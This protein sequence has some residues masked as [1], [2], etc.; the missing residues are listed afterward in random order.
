MDYNSIILHHPITEKAGKHNLSLCPVV[1]EMSFLP[2]DQF[3]K[4]KNIWE[5]NR[6]KKT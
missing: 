6:F 3:Y 4:R 5:I 2:E 1:K